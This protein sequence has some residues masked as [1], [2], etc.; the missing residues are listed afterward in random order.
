MSREWMRLMPCEA[1]V[2]ASRRVY[3]RLGRYALLGALAAL[4]PASAHAQQQA[5]QD[6]A[7]PRSDLSLSL[8]AS[9]W[10]GD[11][12]APTDSRISSILLGLRY[13]VGGLR[14][15]A[16]IPR[17]HIRSDGSI[18]TGIGGTPLYTAPTVSPSQRVR[19]GI[20]DLT[21]GAAY[22]LPQDSGLGFDL[23]VSG[24]VKLPTASKASQLS[25]GKTDY[26]AGVTVSKTYGRLT[27]SVSATYRWFGDTPTWDFQN[28]FELSAGA[29]YAVTDRT[30]VLAHYV[31]TKAATNLIADSHELLAGVSVP[32]AGDRLRLTGFASKGLSK[33]AADVSGGLSLSWR[34]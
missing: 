31:Y 25:T 15:S 27:P 13:R 4:L 1:C 10:D 34:L 18:F 29:S 19:S 14:L 3:G 23:E 30:V 2:C 32:L 22:L 16:N 20:G 17:M 7:P 6:A 33:G 8:G 28:G 21:L 11:F 9:A 26:S 12:G 24:S 5:Q